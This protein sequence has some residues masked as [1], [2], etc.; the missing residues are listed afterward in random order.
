MKKILIGLAVAVTALFGVAA[1]GGY[2]DSY[3]SSVTEE[4]GSYNGFLGY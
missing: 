3:D 1:C 4:D 2:D